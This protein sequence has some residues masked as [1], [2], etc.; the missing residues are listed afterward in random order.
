[1]QTATMAPHALKLVQEVLDNRNDD[2]ASIR[3]LEYGD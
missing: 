1:M 2:I 3:N